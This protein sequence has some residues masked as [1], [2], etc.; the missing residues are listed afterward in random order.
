MGQDVIGPGGILMSHS[1]LLFAP[2]HVATACG[3]L[4]PVFIYGHEIQCLYFQESCL[5][6]EG[7]SRVKQGTEGHEEKWQAPESR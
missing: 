6:Q 2:A 5:T 7:S 4:V 1:N 3:V